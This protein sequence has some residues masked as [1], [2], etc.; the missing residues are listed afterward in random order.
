MRACY[1]SETLF[2]EQ[3]VT[4]RENSIAHIGPF[5]C[6][7]RKACKMHITFDPIGFV[8][9]DIE[10]VP[11]HWTVS[12]LEGRLVIEKKYLDGL[13]DIAKGQRIVAIFLFHHSPKFN[14]KNLIQTP[15]H[16]QKALGVFSICS[17]LRPNP[18]GL[19]VLQ[20]I[21]KDKNIIHVKGLDMED[22]T[23]ILDI[24]PHVTDE[25]YATEPN[26]VREP[27]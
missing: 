7:E 15:R 4:A 8:E 5:T 17:P 25:K 13:K 6:W 1:G 9:T 24:K 11:R 26:L 19:S 18:I 10:N 3:E 20:V 27:F 23:P 22:G 14:P 21:K 16:L 2:L 12:D